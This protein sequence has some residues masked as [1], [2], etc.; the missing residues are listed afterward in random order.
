M[1]SSSG[2][3]SSSACRRS[4]I[5]R[6]AHLLVVSWRVALCARRRV[7]PPRVCRG[8]SSATPARRRR[9]AACR[10]DAS[11]K[12]RGEPERGARKS[13]STVVTTRRPQL[14]QM[15]RSRSP[16]RDALRIVPAVLGRGVVFGA[17]DRCGADHAPLHETSEEH[18]DHAFSA[19]A[20]A[21]CSRMRQEGPLMLNTTARCMSLSR[22]ADAT[23]ASPK[24]SPHA[25]GSGK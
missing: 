8:E 25:P 9:Y 13:P 16:G 2:G 20:R 15:K 24:T 5:G 1:A 14:W 7:R 10:Q 17:G 4:R 21:W 11:Q 3:C 23:T 22:I 19:S 18:G 12:R 6:V